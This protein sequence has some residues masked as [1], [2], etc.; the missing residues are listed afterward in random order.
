MLPSF[1]DVVLWRR[2]A[3]GGT[4]KAERKT[5]A[6]RRRVNPRAMACETRVLVKVERGMPQRSLP[7]GGRS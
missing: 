2:S 1:F 6:K 3:V 5:R 7:A 4:A